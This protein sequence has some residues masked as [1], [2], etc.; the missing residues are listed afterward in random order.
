MTLKNC[1]CF[2]CL[3]SCDDFKTLQNSVQR[4]TVNYILYEL[5]EQNFKYPTLIGILHRLLNLGNIRPFYDT[6]ISSMISGPKRIRKPHRTKMMITT[7]VYGE[8]GVLYSSLKYYQ[9]YI[10]KHIQI[11]FFFLPVGTT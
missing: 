1:S 5:Y 10:Y 4:Y 8:L 7:I 11:F 6:V 3:L 9:L 2:C